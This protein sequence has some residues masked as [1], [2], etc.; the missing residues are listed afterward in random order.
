[1]RLRFTSCCAGALLL[2]AGLLAL[3]SWGETALPATS[4]TRVASETEVELLARE[5]IEPEP[6]APAAPRE[7]PTTPSV[8]AAALP[9]VVARASRSRSDAPVTASAS[10][11][12]ILD[13][14]V[15]SAAPIIAPGAA[16]EPAPGKRLSPADL[17]LFPQS[18]VF[19][20]P[21]QEQPSAPSDPGKLR[22]ARMAR[23]TELG[24]GPGGA[25]ASAVRASAYE[26]A[27]LGSQAT[28][29]VDL[30]RDGSISAVSLVEVS[31]ADTAWNALLR[32]LRK[33][34][35]RLIV[36]TDRPLRVTLLLTNRSTKRAGNSSS[37]FDFDLSNIGSPTIQSLH[38][39]V[40]AQA[41]L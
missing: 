16:A 36:K 25:V 35:A 37:P 33:D 20:P 10:A 6:A 7:P 12:P 4:S 24:L 11:P 28:F 2:H 34:L 22:D 13:A 40:L 1:M 18:G 19:L 39:R 29:S 9:R 38:V 3:G 26:L 8:A 5:S 32:A 17:G 30:D 41:P 31:S 21:M 23:D 27:P 14:A 15:S